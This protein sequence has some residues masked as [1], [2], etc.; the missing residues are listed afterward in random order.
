MTAMGRHAK[1]CPEGL[2]DELCDPPVVGLGPRFSIIDRRS[3]CKIR[4]N[5]LKSH[6]TPGELPRGTGIT[7]LRQGRRA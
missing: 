7:D 1:A 4:R 3:G 2:A 6:Q 5:V